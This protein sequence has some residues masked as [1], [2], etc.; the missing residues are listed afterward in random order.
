MLTD[1]E[2]VTGAVYDRSLDG[3]SLSFERAGDGTII[4]T[5]TGSSWDHFGRCTKGKLK[6]KALRLIQSYQQYVRGW[7]TFHAQTTFYEF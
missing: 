1:P 7:I 3:R 5:E 4:D 6:G 2:E